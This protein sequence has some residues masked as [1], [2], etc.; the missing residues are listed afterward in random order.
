MCLVSF[1]RTQNYSTLEKMKH[2]SGTPVWAVIVI[3]DRCSHKCSWCYGGFDAD[4]H[5]QMSVDNFRIIAGKLRQMGIVQMTITGGDP[6][7]HPD[8]RE[9]LKIAHDHE[10]LIH[11][12]SHGDFIDADLADYMSR[13]GVR[14]VQLNFQGKKRHDQIHGVAGSYDRLVAAIGYLR[15][16]GI[17][18]IATT[19]T[20]GAYNMKELPELF[21][22]ASSLD[23]ERIR[24][25]ETTGYGKKWLRDKK[26]VEIFAAAEDAARERG[27]HDV[28]SYDPEYPAQRNVP[29]PQ[30]ANVVMYITAQ[31]QV[32]FCGAVPGGD[33]LN[34]ID[35]LTRTPEDIIATYLAFNRKIQ[36]SNKPWC[37]ARLG[38]DPQ[39]A[40]SETEEGA[41]PV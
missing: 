26:A 6:T 2:L 24:V 13:H 3:T 27:Y 11:V 39:S 4:L 38:L 28:L 22:E 18:E 32:R 14:Q 25:W 35:M 10:F 21:D 20:V 33:E 36:G 41:L 16:A 30:F 5:D 37:V 19:F 9:F 1:T 15:A 12:C 17:D 31:S 7:E 40:R 8:F 34:I 29:C 23:V